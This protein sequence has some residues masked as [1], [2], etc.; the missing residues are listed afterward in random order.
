M[1]R[2]E[3]INRLEAIRDKNETA[4]LAFY[5]YRDLT[6]TDP[7]P[8]ILAAIQRNPV[9]IE[10]AREMDTDSIVREIA[11]MP[12]ESIYDEPGRIAQPDEV[13]NF[14]RGDGLE[15]ALL[16]A[17]ILQSNKPGEKMIIQ[18]G[19][20]IVS[21]ETVEKKYQFKSRKRLREQRWVI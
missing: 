7:K 20:N 9:S 15:K 12:D 4:D 13:W 8:F 19:D 3:I 2:T 17:N 11:A 5:S 18:I 16:F 10:G 14:G 6:R 21:L 1:T